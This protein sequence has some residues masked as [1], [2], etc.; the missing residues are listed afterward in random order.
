MNKILL[1][2][3]LM[4]GSL[5]CMAQMPY[6]P[7]QPEGETTLYSKNSHSYYVLWGF[8]QETFDKGLVVKSVEAPNG[9][10]Y[11]NNQISQYYSNSWL[12]FEND[13]QHLIFQGPQLL[14]GDLDDPTNCDYA[15]VFRFDAAEKAYL[16]TDDQTFS[17]KITTSGLEVEDDNLIIGLGHYRLAD[18]ESPEDYYFWNGYGDCELEIT[19]QT[20]APVVIPQEVVM[21]E[22]NLVTADGVGM[23]IKLGQDD[24]KVYVQGMY[25]G[26]PESAM[27]GTIN[28]G[29]VD[30][31]AATYLGIDDTNN[32]F[33]YAMGGEVRPVWDE[34]NQTY[35]DQVTALLPNLEMNYDSD[36]K[37]FDC[38]ESIAYNSTS[39]Q[40]YEISLWKEPL[41]K[42]CHH[43]YGVC[44]A[45]PNTLRFIVLDPNLGWGTYCLRCKIPMID[46]EDNILDTSRLSYVFWLDGEELTLDPAQY[47]MCPEP[48][49]YI[50]FNYTENWNIYIIDE[51]SHLVYF[52]FESFDS[53]AVQSIY[54]EEDGKEFRSNIM[55]VGESGVEQIYSSSSEVI[56]TEYYSLTGERLTHPNG[57][58]IKIET[59]SDGTCRTSK[60]LILR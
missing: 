34:A 41:L 4:T 33:V 50:P 18:E 14:K 11:L 27:V 49:T 48:M 30:F 38:I 19:L 43:N 5:S 56:T 57:I 25:K 53:F 46:V 36:A 26:L 12:E 42:V 10:V 16:P 51:V 29:H 15:M 13:G 3:L 22:W 1:Q 58:V 28:G 35:I 55:C 59:L 52:F 8:L 45:D 31:G 21:E 32:H 2:A 60:E 54:T 9:K 47:P 37:V 23:N 17:Y 40:L 7:T 20:D 6:T 39:D 44:P 24:D